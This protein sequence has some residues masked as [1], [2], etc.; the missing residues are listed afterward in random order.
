[1][2]LTAGRGRQIHASRQ[3]STSSMAA[4][5]R[6]TRSRSAEVPDAHRFADGQGEAMLNTVIVGVD[7]LAGGQDAIALA[8]SLAPGAELVLAC[9]YP[10]DSTPSRFALAGYG[11]ALR[12]QTQ[13][14][15]KRARDEAGLD[16][17]RIEL[18][19]DTSPAHALHELAK[20]E[21][22]D[23]VVVGSARYGKVSRAVLG[24]VSRAVLHGSPCPVAVA[25]KGF[26]SS[27]VT[28]VGVAFNGSPEA[29]EALRF[30][31]GLA[32]D[33]GARLRVRG[34]VQ[35]PVMLTGV[36]GYMVNF[37]EVREDLRSYSQKILDEAIANLDVDV[38]VD[39][40]AMIGPAGE[41]LDALCAD[42][43]VVVC[44]SRGWG[45][46]RRVVLGSTSDRLIHHARCPVIVVPRSAVRDDATGEQGELA[47][48]Q[49]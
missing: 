45:G 6:K 3:T 11:T 1:V 19:A 22:A 26:A 36:G 20:N 13:H 49:D 4:I 9:A 47:H 44:G 25:P 23:L 35:D 37:D 46:V 48:A 8:R 5:P 21:P 27:D 24:D 34:A 2:D 18:I 43:D 38:E 40:K 39:A 41:V 29:H 31:A 42:V 30:A 32:S 10:Y 17:A 12:E 7:G 28:V 33:R 15:I 14:E 16:D